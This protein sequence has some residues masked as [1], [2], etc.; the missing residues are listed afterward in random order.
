MLLVFTCGGRAR[1]DAVEPGLANPPPTGSGDIEPTDATLL[2]LSDAPS[3]ASDATVIE[4]DA[5]IAE[6]DDASNPLSPAACA[7]AGGHC[8]ASFGQD[9][10]CTLVGAQVCG[11]YIE[12]RPALCCAN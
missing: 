12:S 5:A 7:A 3:A 4:L 1:S 6:A 11:S 9:A 2:D 8:A 10:A